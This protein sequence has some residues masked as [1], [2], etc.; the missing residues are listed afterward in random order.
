MNQTLYLAQN[1]EKAKAV[2]IQLK[3]N[4]RQ[5][6]WDAIPTPFV[7]TGLPGGP[8]KWATNPARA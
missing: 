2:S 7:P 6:L 1:F 3:A 4:V 8:S 5:Y